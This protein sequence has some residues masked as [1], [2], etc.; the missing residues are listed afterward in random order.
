MCALDLDFKNL[1]FSKI[2]ISFHDSLIFLKISKVIGIAEIGDMLFSGLDKRS[3][4][5]TVVQTPS[6]TM[7]PSK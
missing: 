3:W 2:L 7:T 5:I 1:K 6:F 4:K